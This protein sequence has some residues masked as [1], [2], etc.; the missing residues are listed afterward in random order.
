MTKNDYVDIVKLIRS[1]EEDV[2]DLVYNQLLE[3]GDIQSILKKMD[4]VEE[5]IQEEF[6]YG[7]TE[8]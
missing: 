7:G 5:M 1:T 6:V 4:L 3:E 8:R 2:L